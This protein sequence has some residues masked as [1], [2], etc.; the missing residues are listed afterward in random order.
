MPKVFVS[1]VVVVV[2]ILAIIF[3]TSICNAQFSKQELE[4]KRNVEYLCQSNQANKERRLKKSVF[5]LMRTYCWPDMNVFC[6]KF[7]SYRMDAVITSKFF[8][9]FEVR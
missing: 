1:V 5:K 9:F 8:F 7:S 3:V 6:E 2:V 4:S